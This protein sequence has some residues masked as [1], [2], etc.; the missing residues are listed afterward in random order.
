M[1]MCS[2]NEIQPL[3]KLSGEADPKTLRRLPT[4]CIRQT[5]FNIIHPNAIQ[6]PVTPETQGTTTGAVGCSR[7][8]ASVY[9]PLKLS[10]G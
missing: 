8:Y 1:H 3:F 2:I 4:L 9:L 7:L 6:P 5:V 10:F